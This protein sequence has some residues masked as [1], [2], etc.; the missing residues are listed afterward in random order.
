MK[1][2]EKYGKKLII[3]IMRKDLIL[4]IFEIQF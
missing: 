1:C 2:D 3:E 4:I